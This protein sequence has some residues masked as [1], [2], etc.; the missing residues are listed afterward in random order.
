MCARAGCAG[1]AEAESTTPSPS[2]EVGGK[3]R[4]TVISSPMGC[5]GDCGGLEMLELSL[6]ASL[7]VRGGGML[8][9]AVDRNNN[10]RQE[11]SRQQYQDPNS[12][13]QWCGMAAS[14]SDR[15]SSRRTGNN[16]VQGSSYSWANQAEASRVSQRRRMLAATTTPRFA[17]YSSTVCLRAGAGMGEGSGV[18]VASDWR[19]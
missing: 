11:N 14:M 7:C 18:V 5:G 16:V 19:G 9:A 10:T 15:V 12:S 2:C 1:G 17:I 8:I 6:P 3:R 13:V 4:A